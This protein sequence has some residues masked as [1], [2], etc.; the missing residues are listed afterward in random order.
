MELAPPLGVAVTLTLNDTELMVAPAGTLPAMSNSRSPRAA[1]PCRRPP[2][3]KVVPSPKLLAGN[4]DC[5]VVSALGWSV[6]VAAG[7][8]V[9]ASQKPVR[10]LIILFMLFRVLIVDS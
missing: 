8:P 1:P 4:A 6:T 10:I 9:V 3:W 7:T 5:N 2:A